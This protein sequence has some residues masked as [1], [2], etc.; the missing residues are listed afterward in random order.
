ME[1]H[2][3]FL[4]AEL[5]D[6]DLAEAIKKDY[7]QAPLDEATRALLDYSVKLTLHAHTCSEQDLE[8][9]RGQ[10]FSDEDIVDA[11]ALIGIMN[12]LNRIADALGIALNDEYRGIE[13]SQVGGGGE[14]SKPLTTDS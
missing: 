1:A 6:R 9:L 3:E 11:V 2:G 8:Q 4:R 7:R 12:Y 10:G 14:K 5:G 13:Q